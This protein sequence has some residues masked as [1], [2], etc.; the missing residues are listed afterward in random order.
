MLRH[1]SWQV[2]VLAGLVVGSV[3]CGS[4]GTAEPSHTSL[5]V[6]LRCGKE[7]RPQFHARSRSTCRRPIPAMGLIEIL[8]TIGMVTD[9]VRQVAGERAVVT[10]MMKEGVDPHLY[11]A[12][13]DDVRRL[14]EA[15]V[16]FYCGL[17]LEAPMISLFRRQAE[18]GKPVFAVTDGISRDYLHSPPEFEG[19]YDP[20]VWGD[21]EA[22]SLCVEHIARALSAYDPAGG[23]NLRR[24]R[25]KAYREELKELADYAERD[26]R[27]H[28]RRKNA[29]CSPPMMPSVIS[30]APTRFP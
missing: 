18:E 11:Q 2:C 9:I 6:K 21:V 14:K 3:G 22:W 10:G 15:D 17:N 12:T 29:Y 7:A 19:H 13:R 20:H 23:R 5:D 1:C 27:K 16:V 4:S 25:Q 30:P 26:H 8:C 24:E 28:S